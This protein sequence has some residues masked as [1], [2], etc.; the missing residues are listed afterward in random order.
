MST[1]ALIRPV[2]A[3]PVM[4]PAQALLRVGLAAGCPGGPALFSQLIAELAAGLQAPLV[5]AAVFADDHHDLLHT[6]AVH[7]DGPLS[8]HIDI[9]AARL[10]PEALP[11]QDFRYVRAGLRGRLGAL[12]HA[13]CDEF[14]ACAALM[15]RD[16]AGEALGV[17]LAL[18][19]QPVAQGQARIAEAMLTIVASRMAAEI[20]RQRSDAA[21]HSV[22]LA[23]SAAPSGTVFDELA[24]MAAAILHVEI[25]FI[26]CCEPARAGM[27]HVLA[28]VCDNRLLSPGDRYPIAGTPCGTVLGQRFRAYCSGLQASFPDDAEA[29]EQSLESYAGY[30]LVGPDGSTLGVISVASRRPLA[31]VDRVRSMLEI[32]SVRAAAEV[33]RLRASEQQRAAL[34]AL[35]QRE[36]QYR[37]V[38][39]SSQDGLI[40]WDEALRI[41]DVNPAALAMHRLSRQDVIGRTISARMPAD[42]VES[43]LQMVRDALAGRTTHMEGVVLRP[44]GSSFEADL[45]VMP[46]AQAGRPHALTVLRDVTER[47]RNE[48][49]LRAS[50]EQYR[51]I[52]NSSVDALVLR[53]ADFSIVDV[54]ASYE[55]MSGYSRA[56]VLGVDR[57]L[58]NPPEAGARIRELHETA[59]AGETVRLETQL[60]RRDG[61]CFEL[62]LR[63]VPTL[64]RDQRHVLYIGRDIT[65]AK[66][67]EQALRDSEEQYRAIFNAS[68]DAL[69]LRDAQYRAVEVNPAYTLVSGYTREEVMQAD[70]VL[71]QTDDA[72]RARHRVEHDLALAGKELRFEVTITR[73]DGSAWQAEVRG[74]PMSY[75]GRPHVLYAVRDITERMAAE[76]RRAEL[77]R[78]LRQSQKMEAIGQ[79]TGGLAHD[80]NNILT[81]VLG[82]LAMAQ[83]RPAAE[84]DSTLGR[85]LAQARLAAERARDHVAQLLAFSRPH[86]GERRVVS[87]AAI[88]RGA[89]Q[90]LRPNLPTSIAVE[91]DAPTGVHDALP[92]VQADAV[93]LEQVLMNLCLNARDAIGQHGTI[94]VSIG[95]AGPARHCA[96]CGA[97]LEA[98]RWAAIAVGDDGR[99]MTREVLERMFEPFFTT[100]DAG[101]GTGMGLAMVHGIVHDHGGHIHVESTPGV[102]S[103]F[104]VLLPEAAPGP[105]DADSAPASAD[106]VSA[107]RMRGRVLLVEDEPMVGDYMQELLEGWGLHV[108]LERDAFAAERRLTTTAEAFACLL[109]DQTMPGITGLT[110]ARRALRCR[111]GLPVVVYT[112]NAAD[113]G[114]GELADAGVAALLRKPVDPSAL[115]EL[116]GE[117]LARK[118]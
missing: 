52:F 65:Q 113:I 74:T 84:Q 11:Q 95:R 53:A 112:G 20:E 81:S 102:G 2:P 4:D 7:P 76:R 26:A 59:L 18:D 39:E 97:W 55:V 111:P 32:L 82:Y 51:T 67:A 46:F 89:L 83:E 27:L 62:E 78:Q 98:N 37:A 6:L 45:H 41:V 50:E 23:V 110:L 117:L 19:H 69:V 85:Q 68:A 71:T 12:G 21:M 63:G 116:L 36:E 114:P 31:Q 25:A 86:R 17:L 103:T 38:F 49:T 5:L 8:H 104:Q 106:V 48:R 60:V 88:A 72:L 70:H 57:V 118:P 30:P 58:A 28:M 29:R 33:E 79:L 99:G 3:E 15:L 77:E 10:P 107:P 91:F 73:K 96:S 34:E 100:K 42:Y 101:R 56:E 93:Q 115:R 13:G 43:R 61:H 54:N 66:R 90:L 40:V 35:R 47:R 44:D 1:P 80:F 64:Y 16:S 92:T 87:A 108:T 22:A 14:D 94:R 75:R 105:S 109:T 9:A 24:R